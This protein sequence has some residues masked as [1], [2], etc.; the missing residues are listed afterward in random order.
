MLAALAWLGRR[1]PA[2]LALMVFAGIAVPPLGAVLKPWVSEAVL[3]LLCIAFVQMDPAALRGHLARPAIPLAAIAWTTLAL[4]LLF[5]LACLAGG[6]REISPDLFLAVILQGVASPMMSGPALA[7]LIGLDAALV[8]IT[9]VGATALVP[10]TAPFFAWAFAGE[11]LTL[12]PS[13]LGVKLLAI[14]A[15]ALLA[16][17]VIRRLMGADAI[18][19]RRDEING[20]NVIVLF[21]FVAAIMGDVGAALA[22]DP[23][24]T[25]GLVALAFAIFAA[26]LALTCIA[27]ARAG[28]GRALAIGFTA[29]QRNM[30]LMLAATGG[31]LPDL[32]WL[33]FALAQFPIYLAPRLLAPLARRILD[34]EEREKARGSKAAAGPQL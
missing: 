7:A 5:G 29:S 17:L 10:L 33:Y 32:A 28:R 20:V 18:A 2:L 23:L 16:A 19:R 6:L 34:R 24:L 3:A 9:L 27:F 13:V 26:L 12:S 8:L 4:P 21:I 30:G 1:G 15:G 31:A 14:L 25:L 11:A 22:A